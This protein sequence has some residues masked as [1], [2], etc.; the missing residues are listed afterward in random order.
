MVLEYWKSKAPGGS[1]VNQQVGSPEFAGRSSLGSWRRGSK[2]SWCKSQATRLAGDRR[3]I[4]SAMALVPL[5]ELL[6][7][8]AHKGQLTPK[9]R[10]TSDD[11]PVQQ[12]VEK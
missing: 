5:R 4:L 3:P 12:L 11:L 6:Q 1:E 7:L 10:Q 2:V 9:A 8:R